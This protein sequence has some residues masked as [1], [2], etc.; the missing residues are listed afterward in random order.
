MRV[1]VIGNSAAAISA[2][3]AFRTYDKKSPIVLIARENGPPYSRVLLP[4]VLLGRM[5]LD[6]ISFRPR[7]FY[8]QMNVEAFLGCSV[9]DMDIPGRRLHLDGDREIA[10]DRLLISSGSSPV[11]PP[12]P[13]LDSGDI[14]HLWTVDD[15]IRVN[16]RFR[17][18]NHVLIVGGGFISLMLA[19]VA[20]QRGMKVTVVEILSHVMPQ[21]LDREAA[22]LLETAMV[23]SG[24]RLLTETVIENIEKHPG[25]RYIVYP[26]SRRPFGVD[27]II[28]AAGVRPNLGFVN[29][30][31]IATDR[32][33][34]V[35]DRM[36]ASEPGIYAAGDV[37][38]GPA[39]WDNRPSVH[40][41]WTTAVEHGQTAGANMAGK[42]VH[43]RGSLSSN[44]S[45]FFNLTIA[46]IGG[47]GDFTNA[48]LRTYLDPEKKRYLKLYL[49]GEV[50][51]GGLMAAHPDDVS[52]FGVLKSYILQK[53]PLP[54][55]EV[56]FRRFQSHPLNLRPIGHRDPLDRYGV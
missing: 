50:P 41:L 20:L 47:P 43:Y 36:E 9:V 49:Q 29:G 28:V 38:Q 7:D 23:K 21:V 24:T 53:K 55:L 37:A 33:I 32:G 25:G 52:G 4:Y 54:D 48:D 39:A 11:K 19:W 18:R 40:A 26:E 45:E 44:V 3:E 13:G 34:L 1:A 16:R 8:K 27:M 2:I 42:E 35:N 31:R 14:G 17:N 12:I 6:E 10:F 46:S 15:A 56:L 51:L 5:N 30:D 22:D